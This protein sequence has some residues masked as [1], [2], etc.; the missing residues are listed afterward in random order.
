MSDSD[1]DPQLQLRDL[2]LDEDDMKLEAIDERPNWFETPDHLN[3]PVVDKHFHK[4]E[5]WQHS[6]EKVPFFDEGK[7]G[8]RNMPDGVENFTIL[9]IFLLLFPRSVNLGGDC[10]TDQLV[11]RTV[12]C[13]GQRTDSGQQV[14]ATEGAH[15]VAGTAHEIYQGMVRCTRCIL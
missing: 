4:Q 5:L 13:E 12:L 14:F 2:E 8:P 3:L 9:Q 10:G 11:L 15:V 1:E 7:S 6:E